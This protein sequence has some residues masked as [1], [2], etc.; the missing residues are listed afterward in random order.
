MYGIAIF[1][2]LSVFYIVATR[3]SNSEQPQPAVATDKQELANY[4]EQQ[5]EPARFVEV[6]T[7]VQSLRRKIELC[8]MQAG[9]ITNNDCSNG[10]NGIFAPEQYGTDIIKR[11]DIEHGVIMAEGTEKVKNA[12]YIIEPTMS[13][14]GRITWE[15][16]ADSTCLA[17]NMC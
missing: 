14:D 11:I 1:V 6:I 9:E 2:V 10:N 8:L 4:V 16:S 17:M 5:I 3:N 13:D 12:T 15:V 7:H